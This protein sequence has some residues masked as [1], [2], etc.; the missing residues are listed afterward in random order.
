MPVVLKRYAYAYGPAGNRT[1]EQIDDQ[2]TGA[3][4]D[5]LNRLISQ[6]PSGPMVFQGTVNEAASVTVQGLAAAVGSDNT[7]KTTVPMAMGTSTVT[8]T[9]KATDASG[10]IATKQ[11]E[12]DSFGTGRT[13]TYDANGNLITDGIRTFEWDARSQLVAVNVGTHRSEFTY[14]G[15]KRRVQVVEKEND[16]AQ[17]STRLLWCDTAICEE[18][19]LDGIT[20]SRSLAPLGEPG[21][22]RRVTPVLHP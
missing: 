11:Y 7:F 12:V 9:V 19:A 16:A 14:D 3:S 10:N 13:F 21:A 22:R 20:V 15:L 5:T 6:Q 8:V 4:H 18:R 1:A 2:V 17:S